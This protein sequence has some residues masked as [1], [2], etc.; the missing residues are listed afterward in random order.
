MPMKE[1]GRASAFREIDRFDTGGGWIAHP[2]ETMQRASHVLVANAGDDEGSENR[3]ADVWV[4]DPVDADGLDDYLA[5]FGDVRGVVVLMARHSRDADAI[6]QRHDVPIF[7]PAFVDREYDA[8]TERLSG[9]LPG[10]D[11]EVVTVVDWPGVREVGLYD[12]ETL[13]TGDVLGTADYFL[14]GGE[15][16]G[17]NPIFRLKPPSVLREFSPE[18]ILV[19][20]GEGV[21]DDGAS[22]LEDALDGARWR[23]PRAWFQGLKSFVS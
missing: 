17:V 22:V 16:I 12:G 20:H 8:P 4:I 1:S 10:T 2:D 15:R 7:V 23:A 9:T 3:A 18:R 21:M 13:V 6:A 19:G 14:A 5:E 11:F